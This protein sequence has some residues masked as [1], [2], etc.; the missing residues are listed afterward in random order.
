MV[1]QREGTIE[2]IGAA[3]RE[4]GA[5]D[6]L[7]LDN[8]GSVVLGLVGEQLRRRHRVADRR[9]PA[10]RRLGNRVVLKGPLNVDMPGGIVFVQHGVK[11]RVRVR[12][13]GGRLGAGDS[14]AVLIRD[15]QM[16]LISGASEASAGRRGGGAQPH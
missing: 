1:L 11:V 8:G 5:D 4:A 9:L 2:E 16:L 15:S 12:G 7:I 3:L 10:A 14:D 13:L 6:G